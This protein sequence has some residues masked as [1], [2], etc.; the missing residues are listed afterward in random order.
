MARGASIRQGK[1]LPDSGGG[2]YS[3]G[4]SSGSSGSSSGS[5]SHRSTTSYRTDQAEYAAGG[6]VTGRIMGGGS[7]G[8]SRRSS[9]GGSSLPGQP[10]R[11]GEARETM[12]RAGVLTPEGAGKDI[13][14]YYKDPTTGTYRFI[15][16]NTPIGT[17]AKQPPSGT[18]AFLQM[19]K[20][21]KTQIHNSYL[22]KERAKM[23]HELRGPQ[24]YI[25]DV[26]STPRPATTTKPK[27]EPT[28]TFTTRLTTKLWG[29]ETSKKIAEREAREASRRKQARKDLL[30]IAFS[31]KPEIEKAVSPLTSRI[32]AI[33]APWYHKQQ[34]RLGL[35][36]E[37]GAR[38]K[39]L[40]S[41]TEAE[42]KRTWAYKSH[43]LAQRVRGLAVPHIAGAKLV[44][45]AAA[46]NIE[47]F[48]SAPTALKYG[49]P[50]I[51]KEP[52]LVVP[53]AAVAGVGLG[54]AVYHHPVQTAVT[55]GMTWGITKGAGRVVEPITPTI[56]RG[57]GYTGI[58]LKGF[59]KSTYETV[60]TKVSP[61]MFLE[62][63]QAAGRIGKISH[64]PFT[65]HPA[66]ESPL[67][68]ARLDIGEPAAITKPTQIYIS[69]KTYAYSA[70][71]KVATP[72]M[73]RTK[74]DIYQQ[75]A[76]R[77]KYPTHQEV[78]AHELIHHE[79]P[80]FSEGK[81]MR[82][83]REFSENPSKDIFTIQKQVKTGYVR[84]PI[85]L[86]GLRTNAGSPFTEG[87]TSVYR[88]LQIGRQWTPAEYF[89]AS[90]TTTTPTPKGTL[91]EA[92][93]G[94]Q[95]R[96]GQ[97]RYEKRAVAKGAMEGG[98][99]LQ[100]TKTPI[101]PGFPELTTAE[102]GIIPTMPQ[103]FPLSTEVI[104]P[105]TLKPTRFYGEI[106]RPYLKG[107]EISL[108][109]SKA[110][111][112]W[113]EIGEHK[114]AYG[115]EGAPKQFRGTITAERWGYHPTYPTGLASSRAAAHAQVGGYTPKQIAPNMFFKTT[116]VPE[117]SRFF[118]YEHL[119]RP[120]AP[121]PLAS[122]ET[123]GALGVKSSIPSP[124]RM[125]QPP[126]A[127][128]SAPLTGTSYAE[129]APS[130]IGMPALQPQRT[131]SPEPP[132]R[133]AYAEHPKPN[134]TLKRLIANIGIPKRERTTTAKSKNAIRG[135]IGM[136]AHPLS[137]TTTIENRGEYTEAERR[138]VKAPSFGIAP[139]PMPFG[140]G[141]WNI[142]T[143]TPTTVSKTQPLTLT[144]TETKGG[145]E[146]PTGIG[147]LTMPPPPN[148]IMAV[149][150]SKTKRRKSK[151]KTL[152]K[153]GTFWWEVRNPLRPFFEVN[154]TH[155]KQGKDLKSIIGV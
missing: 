51:A 12:I 39:P 65:E 64:T 135:I 123:H 10:D 85:P 55:M 31:I 92:Q 115:V 60:T 77:A 70:M 113:T 32:G 50:R 26:L 83:T 147:V 142:L 80:Q 52:S 112:R 38:E 15:A 19:Q 45:E 30:K 107:G 82:M 14:G 87:I 8:G 41:L 100:E 63:E 53:L 90:E 46:E 120:T 99:F 127:A 88:G 61:K 79:F 72:L 66:G 73:K 69:P 40:I 116:G 106:S 110:R 71:R 17:P 47:Y 81:V 11:P 121:T 68:T 151:K 119:A 97:F 9:G 91:F 133:T 146:P 105:K 149:P 109:G 5:G 84:E 143:P 136:P 118:D 59:R 108:F 145:G 44:R 153:R 86:V 29:A 96:I 22:R 128:A 56:L 36:S 7:S 132:A 154:K 25:L 150:A 57:E 144:E 98:Y 148:G 74:M 4:S 130:V 20:E 42:K 93:R 139:A 138:Q 125:A 101:P 155:I 49:V 1:G 43:Q 102:K 58:G 95:L 33:T 122:T 27:T 18:A 117:T 89:K 129:P 103:K 62:H 152:K 6:S 126:I 21:N 114:I 37:K 94:T 140:G 78:L 141:A 2:G 104:T 35:G 131:V 67:G 24:G 3:G 76:F 16:R 28:S 124:R 134:P 137:S 48:G 13:V 54:E 111:M 75:R 34:A 23:L